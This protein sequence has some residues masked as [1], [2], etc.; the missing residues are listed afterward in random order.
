MIDR[1]RPAGSPSLGGQPP[2]SSKPL[3]TASLC[4]T[5]SPLPPP[6][7]PDVDFDVVL[8]ARGLVPGQ[9]VDWPGDQPGRDRLSLA[10][11]RTEWSIDPLEQV[12]IAPLL[13][14]D[15]ESSSVHADT[16]TGRP[17]T[18]ARRTG[19]AV[20]V[21]GRGNARQPNSMEENTKT[22]KT[23]SCKG[24]RMTFVSKNKLFKHLRQDGGACLSSDEYAAFQRSDERNWQRIA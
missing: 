18:C 10:G 16:R 17:D 21:A 13:T 19:C 11:P 23:I 8:G 22:E 14:L 4:L 12:L 9:A 2:L 15:S 24:C 5:C 7:C 3:S 1:A 6:T 20:P